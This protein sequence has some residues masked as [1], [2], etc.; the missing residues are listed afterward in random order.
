MRPELQA[1]SLRA[2]MLV[3]VANPFVRRSGLAILVLLAVHVL[4]PAARGELLRVGK[5]VPEAFSFVPLDVGVRNGF[6]KKYGIEIET[7]A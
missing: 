3:R 6:F 7:S 5:A 4:A 2:P 1:S